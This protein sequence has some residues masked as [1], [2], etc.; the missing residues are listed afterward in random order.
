VIRVKKYGS[1]QTCK[2]GGYLYRTEKIS[3]IN[4]CLEI[5][6]RVKPKD[7]KRYKPKQELNEIQR[8][9]Q[10]IRKLTD[11]LA[12]AQMERDD[13]RED[14]DSWSEEINRQGKVI[15]NATKYVNKVLKKKCG[16]VLSEKDCD[17]LLNILKRW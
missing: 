9:K 4:C 6:V 13:L 12:D 7:S 2:Y 15:T 1:Y 8:L 10:K 11:K 16:K 17:E 5:W 3:S 14:Y